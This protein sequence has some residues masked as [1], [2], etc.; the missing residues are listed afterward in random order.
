MFVDSVSVVRDVLQA[1]GWTNVHPDGTED[2]ERISA[3]AL[4]GDDYIWL[5]EDQGVTPHILYADRPVIRIILYAEKDGPAKGKQIQYDLARACVDGV[6]FP[7]GGI[8]R[9]FTLI[10]PYRQDLQGIPPGVVRIS[11]LYEL[12]LSTQEKW[13]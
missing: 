10:R 11:A 9:V 3:E 5:E 1:A 2:T 6:D 12:V 4:S 8:H 7:S 13:D